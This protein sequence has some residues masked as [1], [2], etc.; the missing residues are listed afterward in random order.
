MILFS[1]YLRH[2][3]NIAIQY[4][5]Y[6]EGIFQQFIIENNIDNIEEYLYIYALN[7]TEQ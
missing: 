7:L 2:K 5:I 1:K 4:P 3:V 6:N